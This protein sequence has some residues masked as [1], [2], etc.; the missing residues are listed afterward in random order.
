MRMTQVLSLA[1]W[2]HQCR[3]QQSHDDKCPWHCV[4]MMCLGHNDCLDYNANFIVLRMRATN[5]VCV[6]IMCINAK[7]K[8]TCVRQASKEVDRDNSPAFIWFFLRHAYQI[9]FPFQSFLRT[10]LPRSLPV[11]YQTAGFMHYLRR[12]LHCLAFHF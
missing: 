11:T 5:Q 3:T 10:P 6:Y 2:N 7:L 9:F 1:E 12:C 8:K 4:Q